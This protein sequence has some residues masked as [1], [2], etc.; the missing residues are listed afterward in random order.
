M[1]ISPCLCLTNTHT[2][3]LVHISM[4]IQNFHIYACVETA[5]GGCWIL[6]VCNF[7]Y[8]VFVWYQ[9]VQFTYFNKSYRLTVHWSTHFYKSCVTEIK[10]VICYQFLCTQHEYD[11]QNARLALVFLS[12]AKNYCIHH[13]MHA[14]S[15]WPLANTCKK[16]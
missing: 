8:E 12:N 7:F 2:I 5:L 13:E 9:C 11:S 1:C 4:G 6:S 14:H 16:I 10:L 3:Y 15:N